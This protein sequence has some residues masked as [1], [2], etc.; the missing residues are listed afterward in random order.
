MANRRS[1][2]TSNEAISL[3]MERPALPSKPSGTGKHTAS[4][5]QSTDKIEYKRD[6]RQHGGFQSFEELMSEIKHEYKE[7]K[8]AVD[9]Q[10]L[11]TIKKRRNRM[12]EKECGIEYPQNTWRNFKRAGYVPQADQSATNK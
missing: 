3:S 2:M 4:R 1:R 5:N 11:M 6:M 12:K 8:V 7:E 9:T 10:V